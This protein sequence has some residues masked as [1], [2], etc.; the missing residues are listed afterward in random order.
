M[1]QAAIRNDHM[2]QRI[3]AIVKENL[4]V[5]D[6]KSQGLSKIKE[7]QNGGC[8]TSTERKMPKCSSIKTQCERFLPERK[9]PGWEKHSREAG[10]TNKEGLIL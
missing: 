9:S 6:R 4:Q 3:E 5:E 7:S 10:K 8:T 2:Q 1:Q